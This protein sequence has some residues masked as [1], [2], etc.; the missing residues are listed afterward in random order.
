MASPHNLLI[1]DRVDQARLR[2]L[3]GREKRCS[4]YLVGNPVIANQILG[5]DRRAT[6]TYRSAWRCT[7]MGF[8]RE[9]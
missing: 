5:V 2:S 8:P 7:T 9:R 4:L 6:S 3:S 1:V